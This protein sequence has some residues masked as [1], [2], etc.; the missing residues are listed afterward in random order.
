MKQIYII[1]TF[2]LPLYCF[3]QL[4]VQPGENKES[5]I[6][7]ADELLYVEKQIHLSPNP[8]GIASLYLRNE[9]QLLQGN[10]N[11][12]NTGNGLLS[13]FQE[14]KASAYT[15]N[16]WSS[17][18]D[19]LPGKDRFDE[20]IFEPQSRLISKTATITNE[21]NGKANPLTIS[22]KWIYRLHGS[23][24]AEWTHLGNKFNIDSGE[25][26][27]MKGVDGVN[28]SV[29]IHGVFNNPGNEQRY[30]FR[31]KPNNGLIVQQVRKAE[32]KLIGNPYPSALDLNA[33]LLNNHNITGIAYFWDSAHVNSHYLVDYLGGYGAYSPSLGNNGY[34]PAVFY[35]FAPNGDPIENTG[36][37]GQNYGRRFLPIAQGF[38]VE[39]LENGPVF[40]RNEYREYQKETAGLSEFKS[41]SNISKNPEIIPSIRLNIKFENNYTRQVLLAF[42]PNSTKGIDRAMDAKNLSPLETDAG[43]LIEQ[44]EYVIN[45]QPFVEKDKIPLFLSIS[46]EIPIEISIA[47]IYNFERKAIL[48][49][50][51]ENVHYDLSKPITL[52]LNRGDYSGRFYLSFGEPEIINTENENF[53]GIAIFQNNSEKRTEIKTSQDFTADQI[54]LF[55]ITG[56]KLLEIKGNSDK[57]EYWLSTEKFSNGYYIVKIK[58]P[59]GV[60]FSKKVIISN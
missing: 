18:V 2:F 7:V 35:K 48:F 56:R 31:G 53:P 60:V 17:P 52:N 8:N 33:F 42:H 32:V 21:L 23:N 40:F 19:D 28:T 3:S 27:T 20:I 51:E 25:G 10:E 59:D 15:Y 44:E 38:V 26:F 58:S 54:S 30:D 47:E 6:Y 37:T 45:V 11:N 46:E 5:F 39:G 16:Y 13:V 9:A 14:G 57:L 22:G 36:I 24:Y 1:A 43:W 50:A 34:V 29:N 41:A 4:Y 12:P 49:D 55:D